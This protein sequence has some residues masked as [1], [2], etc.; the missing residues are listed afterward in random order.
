MKTQKR[1]DRKVSPKLILCV[2]LGMLLC[3]V[4]FLYKSGGIDLIQNFIS[5]RYF[6]EQMQSE[7]T[8]KEIDVEEKVEVY[9]TSHKITSDEVASISSDPEET[10]EMQ[11]LLTEDP[12]VLKDIYT[13]ERNEIVLKVF[14][15]A[16]IEYKWEI[17]DIESKEWAL[18]N[19]TEHVTDELYRQISVCK[20]SAKKGIP[21]MIRCITTTDTE[22]HVDI[23][24]IFVLEK[25]IVGINIKDY[26]AEAGK[27]LNILDIPVKVKYEDGSSE[28][29]EGLYGL[30]FIEQEIEKDFEMTLSGNMI[31]KTISVLKE[32]EYC[33]IE[34]EEKELQVRYRMDTCIDKSLTVIGTDKIAPKINVIECS[35]FEVD[36]SEETK[37]INISITA[38]DNNTLYPYL[39]YAFLPEGKKI[40]EKDWKQNPVF[41][42]EVH[43]NGK[44]VAYCKDQ[45]GNIATETKELIAFDREAPTMNVELQTTEW[46]TNTKIYV[47]AE[48]TSAMKYFYSC[49]ERGI[50]SGWIEE[51]QFMVETN[52]TWIVKAQ[53]IVGN[54]SELEIEINN[55]DK[56]MPVIHGIVEG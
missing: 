21:N 39:Q 18:I 24:N 1:N 20:V 14:Y 34:N 10:E 22:T 26:E 37:V 43:K 9:A 54:V 41:E 50:E 31:E 5:N 53:D 29:I 45:S 3:F 49:P 12:I 27:Y 55:I 30:Y 40:E 42:A 38:E 4:Y 13:E 11:Q 19:Q 16:A 23:S 51:N 47:E 25:K 2:V 36:N 32:K 7:Q 35:G 52:G 8:E 46:C 48:D 17:Y 15:P 56:E 33:H 44:W 6:A 28:S